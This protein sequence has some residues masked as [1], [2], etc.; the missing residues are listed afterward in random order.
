MLRKLLKKQG[1]APKRFITDKLKS[2]PVAI[3]NERLLAVHEKGLRAN[4]QAETVVA[5]Q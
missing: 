5:W 1:F 3:R 4:N 2:C